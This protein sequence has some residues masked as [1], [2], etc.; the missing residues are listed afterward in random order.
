MGVL[1]FVTEVVGVASDHEWQTGLVSDFSEFLVDVVLDV[2]MRGRIGVAVVLHL[3]IEAIAVDLVIPVDQ[4]HSVL[5]VVGAESFGDFGAGTTRE[6]DNAL[7]VFFHQRMVNAGLVVTAVDFGFGHQM[8]KID[9]ALVVH[10]QQGDMEALLVVG[11]VVVLHAPGGHVGLQTED[12]FDAGV[13][14]ALIELH[15]AAHGAVVGDCHGFHAL[16]F[17]EL[18][19]LGDFGQTI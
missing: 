9:E 7:A 6:A 8:A 11:G 13:V 3:K 5:A 16:V 19:E 15:Q 18:D 17:D 10:G 2:P 12:G 1:V 14:A 4:L